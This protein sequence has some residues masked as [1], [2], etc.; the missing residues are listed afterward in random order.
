MSRA[1]DSALLLKTFN[2]YLAKCL[3]AFDDWEIKSSHSLKASI[4]AESLENL[5]CLISV[6]NCVIPDQLEDT[7]E[8]L[9]EL[10]VKYTGFFQKLFHLCKY[11]LIMF[12]EVKI[13]DDMEEQQAMSS[14]ETAA[15]TS[16]SRHASQFNLAKSNLNELL[17]NVLVLKK[18]NNST[19]T[20]LIEECVSLMDESE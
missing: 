1:S 8:R 19:L 18:Q 16:K 9:L 20:R 12:A 13:A 11:Y 7:Q 6:L 3:V 15:T 17:R 14:S 4:V 2:D 10:N 5:V